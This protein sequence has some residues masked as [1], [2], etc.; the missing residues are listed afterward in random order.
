[1]DGSFPRHI[2]LSVAAAFASLLVGCSASPGSDNTIK[3][4]TPS[5]EQFI[6]T[7]QFAPGVHTFLENQCATLDCHGVIGRPF[8]LY[9]PTGL[10]LPNDA[11]LIAGGGSQTP[12]ELLANYLSTVEIEPEEM[13]AVVEGKASPQNL[14][15]VKKPMG[16]ERHKGGTRI[17]ADD[18]QFKCLTTWLTSMAPN[19]PMFDQA[20]CAA[21]AALK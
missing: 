11:G 19:A 6:G 10:R 21:A 8:R 3:T 14:L 15:L 13:S 1:M 9:S 18:A 4:T 16:L 5:F 12:A 20:S 7:D 2:G 17:L